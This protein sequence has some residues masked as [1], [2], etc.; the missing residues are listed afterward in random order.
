MALG[1]GAGGV[2]VVGVWREV[3]GA[4]A[5]VGVGGWDEVA[6]RGGG[7]VSNCLPLSPL[8]VLADVAERVARGDVTE[9]RGIA[10]AGMRVYGVSS[11]AGLVVL[12]GK[13]EM[14]GVRLLYEVR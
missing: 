2:L 5:A 1:I 8:L 9:E 3:E 14:E 10:A 6:G 7:A 13:P 11:P 4:L 12:V